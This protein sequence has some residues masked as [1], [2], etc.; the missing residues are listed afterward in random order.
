MSVVRRVAEAICSHVHNKGQDESK[1]RA[2]EHIALQH[3]LNKCDLLLLPVS[4]NTLNPLANMEFGK[5]PE[6]LAVGSTRSNC[7]PSS[8]R[9]L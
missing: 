1:R 4:P 6:R 7:I 5:R 9:R 8:S 2:P 3:F